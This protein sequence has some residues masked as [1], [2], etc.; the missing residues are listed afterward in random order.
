MTLSQQR[1]LSRETLFKPTTYYVRHGGNDNANGL[2]PEKSFEHKER[3]FEQLHKVAPQGR[4]VTLDFGSGEW[5][6]PFLQIQNLTVL[7]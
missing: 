2:S 5:P 1:V 6:G 4:V 3:A 7:F